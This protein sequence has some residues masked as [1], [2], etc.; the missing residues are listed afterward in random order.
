MADK[1]VSIDLRADTIDRLSMNLE[2]EG[3]PHRGPHV[4]QY[5]VHNHHLNIRTN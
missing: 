4:L 1:N 2:A 5:S 3:M